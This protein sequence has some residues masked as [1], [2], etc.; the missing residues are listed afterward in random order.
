[1]IG[2]KLPLDAW[3]DRLPARRPPMGAED[4]WAGT[5]RDL[6]DPPP[7]HVGLWLDRYLVEPNSD[8]E[9]SEEKAGRTLLH[10]AAV[11]AVDRPSRPALQIYQPIFERWRRLAEADGA[12]RRRVLEIRASSRLLLHPSIATSVIEGSLLLHHTYGLPYIPGSALKG[13]CRARA[14]RQTVLIPTRYEKLVADVRECGR[15]KEPPWVTNLFGFVEE[16]TEG[17]LAGL[18]D[19]WDALWIP[20]TKGF[21]APLARDIVNPHHSSYATGLGHPFP[22]PTESPIPT[23]F[24]SVPPG[25]QFLLVIETA[26]IAGAD[27]LLDFVLDECLLPALEFD[28]VGAKTAANYGRLVADPPRPRRAGEQGKSATS[29]S[30]GESVHESAA[31][32]SRRKNDGLIRAQ[33]GPGTFVEVRRPRADTLLK[34]LS[35]EL[36]TR[37]RS[38]KSVRLLVGWRE[39]GN[40]REIV[41]LKEP[42]H[43]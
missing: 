17:G 30:S 7:A 6:P 9:G 8:N 10:H 20:P 11:M 39:N 26:A 40:L 24:L 21:A 4:P 14:R 13:I 43:G 29:A 42:D 36:Q 32:V 37:L 18:V 28:G 23:H 12:T 27:D 25:T 41:A 15:N 34:S 2:G 3:I 35:D 1:M 31:E 19:F 33:I 38:G 5:S 16:D 22:T